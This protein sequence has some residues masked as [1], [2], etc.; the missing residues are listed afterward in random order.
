MKKYGAMF[1]IMTALTI[2]GCEPAP[3]PAPPPAAPPAAAPATPP[4]EDKKGDDKGGEKK[5][6]PAEKTDAKK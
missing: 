4:A 1:A 2:T 6:A 3:T 5:D